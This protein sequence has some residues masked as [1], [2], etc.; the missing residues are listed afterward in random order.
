MLV[1]SH[2]KRF[3]NKTKTTICIKFTRT[4]TVQKYLYVCSGQEHKT[5]NTVH[6][7]TH[8][9][10]QWPLEVKHVVWT[11]TADPQDIKPKTSLLWKKIEPLILRINGIHVS[12][13]AEKLHIG[14]TDLIQPNEFSLTNWIKQV[15]PTAVWKY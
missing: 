2:T 11:S 7:Q 12:A 5:Y 13:S 10:K 8:A 15:S 3:K 6:I 4:K 9:T 14:W 1:P